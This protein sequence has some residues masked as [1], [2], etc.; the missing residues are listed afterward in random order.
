MTSVLIGGIEI[1]VLDFDQNYKGSKIP[2]FKLTIESRYFPTDSE[3]QGLLF[4]SLIVRRGADELVSGIV[5]ELPKPELIAGVHGFLKL[6]CDINLG[7]LYLEMA[8]PLQFQNVSITTAIALLLAETQDSTWALNDT[9]TLSD[10]TITI[11]V[12][13]RETLWAQIEAIR[14]DSQTPFYLRYGGFSAGIH[15]LNIGSFGTQ[16]RSMFAFK[17]DNVVGKPKYSQPSRLPIKE[18]RPVSGKVNGKP[19]ALSDALN[20]D[21]TLATDPDYPLNAS[22]QSILNN[23][24]SKGRRFRKAFTEIK[25]ANNDIPGQTEINQVAIALYR[26]GVREMMASAPYKVIRLDVALEDAPTIFDKIFVDIVATQDIYDPFTQAW[27]ETNALDIQ[28][29]FTIMEWSMKGDEYFA[30]IDDVRREFV[31]MQIYK[32]ELSNGVDIEEISETA[33]IMAS[34]RSNDLEDN[35]GLVSGAFAQVLVTLNHNTVAADC[36]WSG[37]STGKEFEFPLPSIPAG[38]TAVSYSIRSKDPG[39]VETVVTQVPT[40]VDNL[41]LCVSGAGPLAWTVS[42]DVTI[43]VVYTFT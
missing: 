22:R 13:N 8:A 33:L 27:V 19:V 15:Q 4:E 32:L 2:Q 29:W 37:A 41:I 38:A 31:G 36:N 23:T 17:G 34:T 11:D 9:T 28:G 21:P 18:I 3:Q 1:D 39:T 43:E 5:A 10:D 12:R 26:R 24:I 35:E 14:K 20:I 6:T 42:D 25:S 40:L 30:G 7:L 16:D